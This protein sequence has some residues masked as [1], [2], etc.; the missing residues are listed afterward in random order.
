[1][2]VS[3]IGNEGLFT[4]LGTIISE[5]NRVVSGYGTALNTGINNIFNQ[6]ASGVDAIAI[7]SLFATRDS[8]RTVH[9][10]YLSQLVTVQTTTINEQVNRDTPLPTKSLNFSLPVLIAQMINTSDSLKA[11]T[12]TNTVTAASSNKGDG[13][14]VVST[15]DAYG[16]QL[17]NVFAESLIA[18][19]STDKAGGATA[20]S[21]VLS[22][23]GQPAK[24]AGAYDW[25]G[26]SGANTSLTLT[27]P[28]RTGLITDGGF[29]NWTGTGN[30]TPVSWLI[31]TGTAGTQILRDGTNKI[32]SNYAC[33][34]VSD[35]S[36]LT[37]IRQAVVLTPNTVYA[38]SYWGKLSALDGSGQFRIRLSDG[39]TTLTDDAGNNLSST[40]NTNGDLTTS[41]GKITGFF[42]TPRQL[43]TTVYLEL[44]YTTSPASPKTLT[45]DNVG[46]VKA[47]Q[48]YIGGPYIVGFS[49]ATLNAKND[50]YTIAITN[51]LSYNSL[52][53]SLDR[54]LNTRQLGISFPTSSSPTVPDNLI[55]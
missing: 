18:T 35:G 52:V 5:Y 26:G 8:Y 51:D 43:P 48:A 6:Y 2:A 41:F 11:P 1:M 13:F 39:S 53:R 45:I 36:T 32:R 14:L 44:G 54:T 33:Q 12:V 19:V 10:T 21:E 15:T 47:S 55:S 4:R 23:V 40:K 9:G 20:Y 28:E 16:K 24:S 38:F 22:I 30:N 3:L 42:S 31:A 7:D 27:D 50:Y 34:I 46:F 49:K 37:T 25:P 17:D 29:E